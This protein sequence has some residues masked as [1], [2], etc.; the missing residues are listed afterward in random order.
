MEK[1]KWK[2]N[3]KEQKIQEKFRKTYLDFIEKEKIDY[4]KAL[5]KNN[6]IGYVSNNYIQNN[7]WCN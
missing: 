5:N 6:T 1:N 3:K 7:N 4:T 2:L